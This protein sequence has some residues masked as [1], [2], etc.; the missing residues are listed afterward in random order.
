MRIT[1]SARGLVHYEGR[2]ENDK[3]AKTIFWADENG[4]G[5]EQPNELTPVDGHVT[6]SQWF[7]NMA[8]GVLTIYGAGSHPSA[9]TQ[10]QSRGIHGLRRAAL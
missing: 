9:E 6:F 4:D 1:S 2:Q 3:T 10:F 8:P 7:M 5:L